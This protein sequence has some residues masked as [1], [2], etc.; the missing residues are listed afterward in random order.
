[1]RAVRAG[2]LLLAALP[3]LADSALESQGEAQRVLALGVSALGGEPALR[4]LASVRRDYLEDWVEVGQGQHPWNGA[5]PVERLPPH[6]GF[7]DSEAISWLD[8]AGQR[9]YEAI[10]Y[11]DAPNDYAVV[12][13]SGAP[14]R[15]FQSITYV[16]ERPFHV[17]RSPAEYDAERQRLFRRFPEGLL[18]AA[19][20]RPE[21]LVSIGRVEENG[22]RRDAIAFADAS[23]TLIRLYFDSATHLLARA[24][25]LRGHR[26]Y[27]DT[28]SDTVFADY[29]DVGAL[30]LPY[31][32]S[33]RVGGIPASRL[34]IRSIVLDAPS[35][36][37][38][39]EPPADPVE[40]V[41]PP[42]SPTVEALGGG[43]YAIRGA[44]NLLF[45]EF[46]D[47]V[48]LVE[49]PMSEAY[50][51]ACLDL[52]AA[53][54]PG[55][56]IRLIATHFH[57]DHVAGLRTVVARGIPVLTTPDARAVIERSLA[58][59][60]AIRPDALARAPRAASIAVA[61]ERTVLDD[62]RQRIELYDFGPMPHVAQILVAY[63]PRLKLLHV[64]DML[65]VLTPEQ[66]IAGVDGVV[67]AERIRALGLD[68]ERIL[69]M[70]GVPVTMEHLRRG[71]E[72]R[73]KYEEPDP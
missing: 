45:A 53:T 66:V 62:G 64:A 22:T 1:M 47:H 60:Q 31:T 21:T 48:L 52:V 26:I 73:R 6:S 29:R 37:S 24:E 61:G 30:R 18:R 72:I 5:P 70:H 68:V 3:A 16:R 59:R 40:I 56:P 27:G 55:K 71:L 41:T 42:D 49:A 57:F 34:A 35:E 10:R 36:P 46:S 67:M 11:A 69:P 20:D 32:V 58:S 63:V 14:P 38:W 8:Y 9:Y 7:N 50:T 25:T 33:T 54:V 44:Y 12:V 28:T 19:L 65:D 15:A 43:V 23:A 13:E 17:A 2:M 51:A 4:A 39:F